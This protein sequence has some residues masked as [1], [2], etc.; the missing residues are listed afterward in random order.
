M[1]NNSTEVDVLKL[2]ALL[3]AIEKAFS[4]K[5]E[6]IPLDKPI[7]KIS[8][9][10]VHVTDPETIEFGMDT[11]QGRWFKRNQTRNRQERL[12]EKINNNLN[13]SYCINRWELTQRDIFKMDVTE[14]STKLVEE[15]ALPFNSTNHSM[16]AA[17][18][19]GVSVVNPKSL[20]KITP[21]A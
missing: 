5:I 8:M 7:H 19:Y 16:D 10:M 11:S 12:I 21:T 3:S 20:V 9:I 14:L 4:L 1:S 18:Y 6:D 2:M 17:R 13:I 15:S